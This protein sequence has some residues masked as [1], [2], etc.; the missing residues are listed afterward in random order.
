MIRKKA[1]NFKHIIVAEMNLGQ[2]VHE[3]ERIL[4][5]KQVKFYGQMD[6]SLIYP[7]Q[8]KEVIAN[9]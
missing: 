7:D 1:K 6:G 3:I 8:L 9:V 2:Y 4:P 5:E